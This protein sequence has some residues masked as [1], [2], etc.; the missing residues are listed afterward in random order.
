VFGGVERGGGRAF[1]V[2]MLDRSAE[3]LNRHHKTVDSAGYYHNW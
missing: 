1:L 3:P 2:A